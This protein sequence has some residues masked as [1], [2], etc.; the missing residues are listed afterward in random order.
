[1]NKLESIVQ[2]LKIKH[3]NTNW[4]ID[5]TICIGHKQF[6]IKGDIS[7][8]GYNETSII[9]CYITPQLNKLN[10]NVIKTKAIIDVFIIKNVSIECDNYTKYNGKQIFVCIIA[11][12]IDEPYFMDI[13]TT[14]KIKQILHECLHDYYSV[15][16]KDVYRYYKYYMEKGL[17][18][19]DICSKYKDTNKKLFQENANYITSFIHKISEDY[20]DSDDTLEFINN[21]NVKFIDDID[22]YLKRCIDLFIKST[23]I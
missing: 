5:H 6:T 13:N 4:N 17:S 9:L 2:I 20:E 8:I 1:M 21:L 7:V 12:N 23:V 16:N 22:A 15:K 10:F 3:P 14:P 19:P 11:L 18:I